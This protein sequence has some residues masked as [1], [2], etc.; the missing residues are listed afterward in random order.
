MGTPRQG[1]FVHPL[2]AHHQALV[3]LTISSP[4]TGDAATFRVLIDSGADSTGIGQRV[5]DGL[6]LHDAENSSGLVSVRTVAGEIV[7]ERFVVHIHPP[8]RARQQ[9]LQ[10]PPGIR[11][12]VPLLE[13]P[14]ARH[15]ALIGTDVLRHL[16]RQV[17]FDFAAGEFRIVWAA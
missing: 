17:T 11:A 14:T 9:G 1:G 10:P 15:D 5:V 3:D 6:G 16:T 7:A 8:A 13:M 4:A 12:M 2:D